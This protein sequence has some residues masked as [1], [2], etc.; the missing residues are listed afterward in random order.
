MTAQQII[1]VSLGTRDGWVVNQSE[2]GQPERVGLT[3]A[4]RGPKFNP[5]Q[6]HEGSQ[7]SMYSYSVL[8]YIQI[9]KSTNKISI[10]ASL[11]NILSGSNYKHI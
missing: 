3:G 4:S 5:Q 11:R 6:P 7:P 8:I 2:W 1:N 9:N 10:I